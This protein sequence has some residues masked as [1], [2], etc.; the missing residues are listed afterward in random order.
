MWLERN[1]ISLNSTSSVDH[2]W[3]NKHAYNF[4][5]SGPKFTV[6]SLPDVGGIVVHH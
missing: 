5:I 4:L 6:F 3:V 1:C 2:G